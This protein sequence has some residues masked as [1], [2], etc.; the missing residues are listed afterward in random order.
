MKRAVLFLFVFSLM[1]IILIS[2]ASAEGN[3]TSCE[4]YTYST[5][6]AGCI[7]TCVQSAC[8]NQSVCTQ[9]CEGAGSCISAVENRTRI[10]E[11][12]RVV[13]KTAGGKRVNVTIT[14]VTSRECQES[15]DGISCN[16]YVEREIEIERGNMTKT[17]I[18]LKNISIDI[19]GEIETAGNRTY[20]RW[21]NITREVKIMP[22]TA[23][24]RALERLRLKVCNPENNCTIVLKQ[25][26]VNNETGKLQYEIKA[27]KKV[28]WLWFFSKWKDVNAT[29]DAETG[30]ITSS[31]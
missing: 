23:N 6:P 10:A 20:I 27:K 4:S 22:D 15:E 31:G 7:Q 30:N 2:G 26:G 29:V 1:G 18:V 25:T 14:R 12:I 16:R 17:R 9:D 19:N 5:C 24:E 3:M 11:G 8:G 21:N 28:R 13:E